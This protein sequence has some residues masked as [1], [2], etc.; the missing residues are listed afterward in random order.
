MADPA[1]AE[2]FREVEAAWDEKEPHET[3]LA[4]ARKH[5]QLAQAATLY[6]EHKAAHPEHAEAADKRLS[7][8]MVLATEALAA[9]RVPPPTVGRGVWI[10]IGGIFLGVAA[11]V[12]KR[13][14]FG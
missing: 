8:I 3:L 9:T 6:R 13:G 4:V 2:L 7:T 12:V 11:Y 1:I 14:F 5:H 10:V